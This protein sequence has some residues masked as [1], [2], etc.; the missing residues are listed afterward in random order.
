MIITE[1]ES[2][3]KALARR[4]FSGWKLDMVFI[5]KSRSDLIY[6]AITYSFKFIFF[7]TCIYRILFFLQVRAFVM[8][9]HMCVC[10]YDKWNLVF[11]E[12]I[13]YFLDGPNT[14]IIL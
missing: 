6:K 1:E 12:L 10:A 9:K 5:F 7:Y 14:Y 4:R 11:I 3:C 2:G 8:Y 13:K